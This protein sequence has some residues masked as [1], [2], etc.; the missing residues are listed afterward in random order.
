MLSGCEPDCPACAEQR[1]FDGAISE[2]VTEMWGAAVASGERSV[3][4]VGP[5]SDLAMSKGAGTMGDL[6]SDAPMR[7]SPTAGPRPDKKANSK[8]AEVQANDPNAG[9]SV[10]P[11]G[12]L[13]RR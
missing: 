9:L 6:D 12:T 11:H 1:R 4:G 13:G 10:A 8:A 7:S 2:I 3:D 5:G